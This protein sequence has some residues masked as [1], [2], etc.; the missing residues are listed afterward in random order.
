MKKIFLFAVLALAA[1]AF[2]IEEPI[3]DCFP[4]SCA[5]AK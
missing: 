5:A 2:A 4:L 3:P 1:A